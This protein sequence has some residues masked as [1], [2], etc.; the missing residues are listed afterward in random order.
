M[1][2]IRDKAELR[3]ERDRQRENR[4]TLALVPTMGY[5]HEGHLELIREGARRA[6][7]VAVSIFVNPLQFNDP[8]DF[9]KYPINTERDLEMCAAAGADLV[10]LPAVDEMYPGFSNPAG[11]KPLL[12]MSMPELTRNLC[13]EYRPGHFDGV[14]M[15]V[16][17]LFNLFRPEFGIFGKKDYQQ[18]LVVRRLAYDLDFGVEV[19]G[20][21]TVR[22][23]DGLAM[24][25]RNARLG[26]RGREQ[27]ALIH[28]AFRIGAQACLDGTGD[29]GELKEIMSDVI[30]SGSLN[31][32]EYLE[33]LDLNTLFDLERVGPGHRYLIAAGVFCE[34]V[35][36]IDNMEC[37][38]VD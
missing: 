2:V 37:G 17:R 29:P 8:E 12:K 18:Y 5:L 30:E 11:E 3:L 25:S 7:Q 1:K 10:F 19:V 24:S 36:L 9:E 31:K 23:A 6:D 16:A 21:D 34:G 27:A 13:G 33:I 4:R 38:P 28:R 32:V 14:L 20:V 35:R 26:E 15:V 22:E